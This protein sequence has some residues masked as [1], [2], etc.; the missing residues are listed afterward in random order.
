MN[1]EKEDFFNTYGGTTQMEQSVLTQQLS[2]IEE[3]ESE[4]ALPGIQ[5]P[6]PIPNTPISISPPPLDSQNSL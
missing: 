4:T 5:H 1:Q 6:H 2:P 3:K